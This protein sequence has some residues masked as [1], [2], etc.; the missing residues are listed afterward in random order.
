MNFIVS[1]YVPQHAPVLYSQQC[2]VL[3]SISLL[4]ASAIAAVIS[5]AISAQ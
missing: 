4:D 1:I 3:E 5:F 2:E